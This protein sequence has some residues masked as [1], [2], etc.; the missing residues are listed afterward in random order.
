MAIP[1]TLK[2]WRSYV[3]D[4]PAQPDRLNAHRLAALS[5]SAL[6]A[7]NEDRIR[8][9]SSDVVLETPDMRHLR[10]LWAVLRAEAL[11][12]TSIAAKSLAISG[13]PTFGKTTSA[14]W[15][16]RDHERKERERRPT[17]PIHDYQPSLY[18]VTPPATTP[19]M[20]MIAF[21]NV[22]GLPYTRAQTAQELTE[23]VVMVLRTLGTS[24]IVLD[25]IHNVQSNRQVGAEAA[26]TLKLFAERLNCA[27]V[28]AGIDLDR[29]PVFSGPVGE[30]L[31]W[32]TMQ[33][34]MTSFNYG[35][36]RAR[37]EWLLLVL[38]CQE[39]LVLARQDESDLADCAAWLFDATGGSI[40]RLRA[41]LRRGSID[42]II[43]GKER[44]DRRALE[45]FVM[46]GERGSKRSPMT[47]VATGRRP[48]ETA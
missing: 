12:S 9:L 37:E 26:S 28:V 41:L 40:G 22:L 30:Q 33:Y 8:W 31:A 47:P 24:L 14:L 45:P 17:V 20:L 29:S 25:E 23:R 32:R 42:A 34:E 4:S 2:T 27:F 16:A 35:S 36:A 10:R 46:V 6:S 38:S 44:I 3:M 48:A 18:V 21:C 43:N 5:E 19:K 11:F 13:A 15:I 7:Y 1:V 39:L